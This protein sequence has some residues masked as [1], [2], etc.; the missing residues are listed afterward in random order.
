MAEG[1]AVTLTIGASQLERHPLFKADWHPIMAMK[2]D[3]EISAEFEDIMRQMQSEIP[4]TVPIGATGRLRKSFKAEPIKGRGI[5]L[6]GVWGTP[7]K[8]GAWHEYGTGP[9]FPPVEALIPW[10]DAKGLVF[11]PR[12]AKILF[13]AGRTNSTYEADVRAVAF[14]VARVISRRGTIPGNEVEKWLMKNEVK[15]IKRIM[16]KLTEVFEDSVRAGGLR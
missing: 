12:F 16:K 5:D 15:T 3:K 2:I 11:A 4:P 6:E 14:I 7:M 13:E 9:H 10:V 8:Y 1:P